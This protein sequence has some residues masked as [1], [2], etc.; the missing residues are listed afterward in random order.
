MLV[1]AVEVATVVNPFILMTIE[2][3][4]QR[5]RMFSKIKVLSV[6]AECYAHTV[7]QATE[8]PLFFLFPLLIIHE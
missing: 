5:R 4:R 3:V 7:L 1:V 6:S 2:K 8:F